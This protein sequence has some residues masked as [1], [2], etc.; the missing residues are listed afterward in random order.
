ME[1]SEMPLMVVGIALLAIVGVLLMLVAR[2]NR[3]KGPEDV[4]ERMGRFATREEMLTVSDS[5]GRHTPSS[6]AVSLEQIMQGRSITERTANVLTRADMKL[7]VGEFFL[8]RLLASVGGF[9]LGFV[10]VAVMAPAFGLIIGVVLALIG[11]MGPAIYASLKGNMRIKKFIDQL[12]DTITL[13]AN[14]LR[15]GYSL[16]Q[17]M[18]LVSRE[19]KDPIATEFRRVVRE[20]GLGVS[21]EDAMQN[22]LR[23][24][25]S[26][27]LDLLVTAIA[28][29][30]E[31]GGNLAQ[32]LSTIGH[33][34][35]ERV[36]IKGE[37]KVLT[38]QVQ[39]SGYLITAMPICLAILIFLMNP[40]YISELFVWPWICMPIGAFFM[41]LAG[42]FAMKKIATIEV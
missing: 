12:G 42:F 32:I 1:F 41:V 11:F 4:I 24:V 18:E 17:T 8:I 26:E 3:K 38:A 16:L 22:M 6:M 35:R 39:L 21:T 25:P 40:G 23:R 37:V 19:A 36:R 9:A 5:S 31:V 29:Q 30:H 34:I 33:T 13:M 20:V 27:D 28:I 10:F 7:T 2:N 14:S 15:A